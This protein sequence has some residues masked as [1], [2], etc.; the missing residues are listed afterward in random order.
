MGG[1]E[2][3]MKI[4]SPF[5]VTIIEFVERFATTQQ[6]TEI[7]EGFLRFRAGLAKIGVVQGIQWIDGSF[8]EDVES[9]QGRPP[10]DI[11]VITFF[12]IP[13]GRS[14]L[15]LSEEEIFQHDHVKSNFRT[16]AYFY[17]PEWKWDSNDIDHYVYWNSLFS[18]RRDRVWKGYVHVDLSPEL[19]AIAEKRVRVK[20]VFE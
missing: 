13:P 17:V 19:D 3:G 15:D 5:K 7:I 18:H 1:Y 12:P 9:T 6:R 4:I 11:D 8:V 2:E 14:A 10:N 20:G 16:D